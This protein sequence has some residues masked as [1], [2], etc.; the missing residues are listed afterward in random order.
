MM[1]FLSWLSEP[2]VRDTY[3]NICFALLI[4]PPLIFS[5]WYHRR[6]RRTHEG[7]DLM[8]R[9]SHS[10]VRSL[11]DGWDMM[12]D[13]ASGRYGDDVRDTQRSAYRFFVVWLVVLFI[14]FGGLLLAETIASQ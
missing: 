2:A 1:A 13:I 6:I 10:S 4:V 5:V 9:Q 8:Q 14:A 7:R 3:V 12:R 11:R